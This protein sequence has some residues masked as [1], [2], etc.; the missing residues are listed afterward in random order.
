MKLTIGSRGSRLALWQATWVQ[1]QLQAAGHNAEIQIIKTSGDKLASVPLTSSGNKGLFTKEIEEALLAKQI[2]V[3]VH[4]LKDLPTEQ[5][6]GLLIAAI[7]ER[8]DPRDVFVSKSGQ[9]F[10]DLPQRARVGTS[11]L[12]R[13]SQLLALRRDL[14][15]VSMRGNVDT[16]LRKLDENQCD[17][18]VLAAAGLK[19][20]GFE[21]RITGWFSDDQMC[22]AV[23]QGALAIQVRITDHEARKTVEAL[24]HSPSH[25]A[26]R[27]ERAMLRMLGGGCMVP[28][29]GHARVNGSELRLTGIVADPSGAKVIRADATGSANDPE[30]LGG[31]VAEELL[32]RGA[33]KL[34]RGN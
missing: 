20:L 27:A 25:C 3:A 9:P 8:E 19:R 26:V 13:Q 28:I 4:S 10:E 5:P 21:S 6:E 12:R 24:D 14:E 11:S 17:A 23:G 31:R 15:I 30:S 34:L 29:A 32:G 7:P 22:P 18:L 1:Q 16:R 2:D 33:Q